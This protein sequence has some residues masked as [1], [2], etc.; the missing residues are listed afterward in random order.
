[1]ARVGG[2]FPYDRANALAGLARV[3]WAPTTIAVPTGLVI[4]SV[5]DASG[6]YLPVTGW[7]DFGLATDAPTYTHA[8]EEAELDYQQ[9]G[10]LFRSIASINRQ[11]TA[12]VAEIASDTMQ[13]VENST[14]TEAVAAAAGKSAAT[15]LHIGRYSSMTS[16]RVALISYRPDGAGAVVEPAPSGAT[17][18]PLVQL[19]LPLVTLAAED[20]DM[21]FDAGEPVAAEITFTAQ[22]VPGNT[23]GRQ[24]GFWYFEAA[25]T[26]T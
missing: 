21:E 1:M 14:A 7:N 17:R 25:G 8:K 4:A 2:R 16:Y 24:H 15:K 26:I 3:L 12:S 22:D 20:T 19:V 13:I 11:F 10:A 18:P 6:E 5:A 23:A 9:G